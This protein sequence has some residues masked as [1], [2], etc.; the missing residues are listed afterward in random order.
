M[1]SPMETS[2][3]FLVENPVTWNPRTRGVLPYRQLD[4]LISRWPE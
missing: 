4:E 3:G 1:M 2:Y